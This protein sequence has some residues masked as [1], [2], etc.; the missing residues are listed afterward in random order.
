MKFSVISFRIPVVSLIVFISLLLS[1]AQMDN[2]KPPNTEDSILSALSIEE[3]I[4]QMVMIG[5]PGTGFDTGTKKV[6]KRYHPGGIILFGY[7]YQSPQQLGILTTAIQDYAGSTAHLPL[8][9]ATDQEGGRVK[10]ITQGVT[11]FAGNMALGSCDDPDLTAYVGR[12]TGIELRNLGVNMNLAPDVDVNNNPDNPII[13]TRS[14]GSDPALVAA[15]GVAYIKGLQGGGCLAVAKHYPGHGDTAKDSHKTLPVVSS[16][17]DELQRVEF[18]PFSAAIKAQVASV[19]SA[20]ILYPEVEKANVPAT[21]SHTFLSEL[22]REKYGFDGIVMTDDLEMGAIAGSMNI[23]QASVAAVNA[24][25]DLILVTTHNKTGLICDALLAAYTKG[26]LTEER[27]DRSVRRIVR[28]KIKYRIIASSGDGQGAWKLK[29]IDSRLLLQASRINRVVSE[30]ALYFYPGP[31]DS[32]GKASLLPANGEHLIVCGTYRFRKAV[33][34]EE[35]SVRTCTYKQFSAMQS[36]SFKGARI[37]YEIRD[38]NVGQIA[39]VRKKTATAN[40]VFVS[41]DNPFKL[42]RRSGDMP[43]LFS[44]SNTGESY[45]ALARA[46]L[47]KID[48]KENIT[49]DLGFGR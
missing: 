36:N 11:Q 10:R 26:T 46:V 15:H 7:N 49:I 27:I 29:S 14:F 4:G 48:V 44:F 38:S 12:I 17:L 41:T 24:G 32:A 1:G 30:R 20:H 9:I 16:T 8:F 42:T 34:A 47:G 23:G 35:A 25:A 31:D 13:N 28:A 2:Q 33:Q 37:Y 39:S 22:L 3:K 45:N 6:I 18:V 19:M 43:V 5:I 21:L 40:L